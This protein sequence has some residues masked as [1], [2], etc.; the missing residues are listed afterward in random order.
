M[1]YHDQLKSLLVPTPS[2]FNMVNLVFVKTYTKH[3]GIGGEIEGFIFSNKKSNVSL[4]ISVSDIGSISTFLSKEQMVFELQEYLK[5]KKRDEE[6]ATDFFAVSIE[7]Y[8]KNLFRLIENELG[9]IVTG[10]RWED[11][12]RDWMGYK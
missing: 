6:F 11:I 1:K 4:S 12:P 2:V 10:K 9:D 7:K 8:I 3:G 5:F